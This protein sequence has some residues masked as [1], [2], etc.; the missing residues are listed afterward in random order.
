MFIYENQLEEQM[1]SNKYKLE[2]Q[3]EEVLSKVGYIGRFF[4]SGEDAKTNYVGCTL[5]SLVIMGVVTVAAGMEDAFHVISP[6]IGAVFGYFV[7][8]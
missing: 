3:R 5:I 4:G 1:V 2:K 6:L 7:K 8:K